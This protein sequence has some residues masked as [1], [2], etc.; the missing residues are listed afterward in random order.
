MDVVV[1]QYCQHG[2][3]EPIDRLIVAFGKITKNFYVKVIDVL[4]Q[5]RQT[6]M[7]EEIRGQY[8]N[9][10]RFRFILTLPHASDVS[11][12]SKEHVNVLLER[13]AAA[14]DFFFCRITINVVKSV[15]EVD[16]Q[17][18]WLEGFAFEQL[19]NADPYAAPFSF[20]SLSLTPVS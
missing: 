16:A 7:Q 6:R 18:K 19:K 2:A 3:N 8:G 9:P 15:D 12:L 17:L 13:R 14:I 1:A 20:V 5:W 4:R 11:K 10:S